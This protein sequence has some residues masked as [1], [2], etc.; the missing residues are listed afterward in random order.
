MDLLEKIQKQ[1]NELDKIKKLIELFPD[2]RENV[3]RWKNVK[4]ASKSANKLC[5]DYHI[6]FSC[7]CCADAGRLLCP[8][9]ETEFG[10]VYSDPVEFWIGQ[11]D[12][13]SLNENWQQQLKDAE[14]PQAIIEKLESHYDYEYD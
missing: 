10:R 2:L 3:D 14:I 1:Q 12:L 5:T 7:G 9:V 8:F 11:K 13:D 6:R 4:Y